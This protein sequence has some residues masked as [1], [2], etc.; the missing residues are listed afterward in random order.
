MGFSELLTQNCLECKLPKLEGINRHKPPPQQSEKESSCGCAGIYSSPAALELYCEFF[1]SHNKL[2]KLEGFSS[3]FGAD[4]YG[5]PRNN[6]KVTI[7]KIKWR[8]AKDFSFGDELI[9]PIHAG[10][11]LQ[12][13]ITRA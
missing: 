3:F 13:Q 5:L 4:F 6:K 7:E 9:I 8:M 1:D 10:Q 2:D 12:W 11:N